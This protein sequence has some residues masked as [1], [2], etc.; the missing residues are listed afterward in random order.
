MCTYRR[1]RTGWTI[2]VT[3]RPPLTL[4][5]S[6]MKKTKHPRRPGFTKIELDHDVIA[7]LDTADLDTEAI[8]GGGRRTSECRA[9]TNPG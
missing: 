3:D 7:D 1:G 2:A 6:P 5:G 9:A 4:L 8:R